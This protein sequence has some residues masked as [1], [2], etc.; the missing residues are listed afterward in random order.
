ML[1]FGF[2]ES[3]PG[4]SESFLGF[5]IAM[6]FDCLHTLGMRFSVKH[7]FS[8]GQPSMNSGE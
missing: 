5:S 7:T 3:V 8:I 1:L 6:I 4:F 2:A